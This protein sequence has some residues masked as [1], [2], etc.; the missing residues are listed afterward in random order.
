[1]PPSPYE[2][3]LGERMAL[4]HPRLLAYFSRIPDGSHGHGEGVFHTVGTPRRWLWPILALLARRGI[5]FPVWA[6]EVPFTVTN[7]PVPHAGP[8]V[9]ATR[10]FHFASGDR[11]M[12]DEIG[13]NGSALVD[14]LGLGNRLVAAF[15]AAIVDEALLL[16]S[17]GVGV[18]TGRNIL[19]SPR[20]CA[21]RVSLEERFDDD[22][23][24]QRVSV[25][26]SHPLLGRLYEYAGSFHYG[27]RQGE[28]S[29]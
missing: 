6:S 24:L 21:P 10:T 13:W 4:L 11:S 5:L 1:M 26:L 19:W 17:T 16:V 2:A 9:A 7:S 23:G 14:H 3:A 18:R 20:W 28:A 27:I 25:V 29:A 15:D 22:A 8:A 12:V